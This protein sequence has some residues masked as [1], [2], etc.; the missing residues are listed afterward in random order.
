M[1]RSTSGAGRFPA[2]PIPGTVL[3]RVPVRP[4]GDAGESGGYIPTQPDRAGACLG[5]QTQHRHGIGLRT[6]LLLR[7]DQVRAEPVCLPVVQPVIHRRYRRREG[8]AARHPAPCLRR[9]RTWDTGGNPPCNAFHEFFPG[10]L[11]ARLVR[12]RSCTAFQHHMVEGK[13]QA[14]GRGWALPS[15][16]PE[17]KRAIGH[18]EL[19]PA[20]FSDNLQIGRAVPHRLGPDAV[21]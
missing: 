18:H 19:Q 20:Q 21:R 13:Q 7:S 11:Q 17:R 1:T 2:V 10:E 15:Q 9:P 5:P 16:L 12:T 14:P 3:L 8:Q 6:R 4:P